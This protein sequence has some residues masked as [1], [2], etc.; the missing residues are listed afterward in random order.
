MT[1]IIDHQRMRH[2]ANTPPKIA[3]EFDLWRDGR[4]FFVGGALPIHATLETMFESFCAESTDIFVITLGA[5]ESIRHGL[6]MTKLIKKNFNIRVM[7]RLNHAIP[8]WLFQQIYASGADLIDITGTA[9]AAP[10]DDSTGE[11]GQKSQYL[12]AR[13]AFPRWSVASTVTIDDG[14]RSL[15]IRKID[16]LLHIGIVPLPRLI[17]NGTEESETEIC[18]VL[19]HV[20]KSWHKHGV[21][22]KPFLALIG[23]ASPLVP[24]VK[25]GTLRSIIDRLHDRRKLAAADLL[26]HL[27]VSNPT[28]SLDSAGL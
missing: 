21:P 24:A 22:I 3:A 23:L 11:D 27:R 20:T 28:D 13:E 12:A 25:P 19:H 5:A 15:L 9:P 18:D 16:E 14:D 10:G 8:D 4:A 26:R 1:F 7:V 2:I 6:E 17:G